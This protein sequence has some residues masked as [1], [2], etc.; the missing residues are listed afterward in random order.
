MKFKVTFER[1]KKEYATTQ[2]EA[3]RIVRDRLKLQMQKGDRTLWTS[4]HPNGLFL[5]A[6]FVLNK[7]GDTTDISAL[8]EEER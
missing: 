3:L 2:K 4:Q 5:S 7:D 8:V 1:G 6:V